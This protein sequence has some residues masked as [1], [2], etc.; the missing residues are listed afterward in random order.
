V[1]LRPYHG[2]RFQLKLRDGWVSDVAQQVQAFT[3]KPNGLNLFPRT[4]MVERENQVHKLSLDLHMQVSPPHSPKQTSRCSKLLSDYITNLVLNIRRAYIIQFTGH[5]LL[6]YSS[7]KKALC[8]SRKAS[9]S[10]THLSKKKKK[11]KKKRKT[12]ANVL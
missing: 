1:T 3:A 4:Q 7:K 2:G 11:K 5:D 8:S 12:S 6:R 9:K 10:Q